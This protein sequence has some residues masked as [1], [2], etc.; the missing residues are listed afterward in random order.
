[1]STSMIYPPL[2]VGRFL[3]LS[4]SQ[5]QPSSGFI[6]FWGTSCQGGSIRLLFPLF[7]LLAG[8]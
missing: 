8:S 3:L 7:L 6:H 4:P 5:S 2:I 1:M